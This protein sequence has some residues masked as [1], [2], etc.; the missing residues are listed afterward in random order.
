MILIADSGSTKCDWQAVDGKEKTLFTNTKGINPFFHDE[1]TIESFILSNCELTQLADKVK[2]VFIYC[3]G[4]SNSELNKIVASGLKRVFKNASVHVEHDLLGAAYSTFNGKPSITCILGTGSNSISFDGEKMVEKVP[5]LAYILGDEG[6][7]SYFGKRLLSDY[8]YHFLPKEIDDVL[9]N[10]L[11]LT[12]NS[13]LENVY[14]KPYANVYLA[15]FMKTIHRF[16]DHAYF[17]PILIE[18]MKK[19][20]RIHVMCYDNYA[21]IP[22]NFIG[23]VAHFFQ[24]E[25]RMA[26]QEL[27]ITIG[28]ICKKPI[29]GLVEYHLNYHYEKQ[30]VK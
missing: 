23:S 29:D 5:A 18:G 27:N 20:L 26:A 17:K 24:D 9:R 6:S 13:I 19:F 25:L 8:L 4:G 15:S 7:G 10:E 28:N 11:K 16:K 14:M 12:K 1:A 2:E 21:S 3:A 22:V 30:Q